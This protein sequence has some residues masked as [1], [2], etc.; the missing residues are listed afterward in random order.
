M[1]SGLLNKKKSGTNNE[2]KGLVTK[3]Q[4]MNFFKKIDLQ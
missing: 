4:M 3:S 2:G 1:R